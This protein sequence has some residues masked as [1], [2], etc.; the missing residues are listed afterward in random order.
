MIIGCL[1]YYNEIQFLQDWHDH[2]APHVDKIIAIDGRIT[3][4][5]HKEGDTA[6]STDG[7]VA[8]LSASPKV[9]NFVTSIEWP[10][11]QAKRSA[12]LVGQPGDWYF[13]VDADEMLMNGD[14]LY[15]A[16][17]SLE[18]TPHDFAQIRVVGYGAA[19]L[20]GRVFRHQAGLKYMHR[21]FW[22]G[23]GRDVIWKGDTGPVLE[24]V[25]LQHRKDERSADRIEAKAR[26]QVEQAKLEFPYDR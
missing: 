4:F 23:Q 7:G 2:L 20:A 8:L 15:D 3:G 21:H 16:I 26:Y 13:V 19:R 24:D 5:P 18:G 9:D 25:Y 6:Y 12:Y 10:S 11:E 22:L 1:I 14:D 17:D